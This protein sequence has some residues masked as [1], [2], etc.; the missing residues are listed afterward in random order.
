MTYATLDAPVARRNPGAIWAG[1]LATGALAIGYQIASGGSAIRVVVAVVVMGVLA[2]PSVQHPRAAVTWLFALLPFM[3][4]IR[5]LFLG[6]SGRAFLDPLLLITSAV[7]III[8][9]SMTVN[10]QMDFEGTT[11]SKLVFLL[12]VVGL[13]Q[14]FNPEQRSLLTGVTGIMINLVPLSFFFIGRTIGD[15][16]YTHRLTRMVMV[17][18]GL[19]ALYGLKQVFMGFFGFEREF[20]ANAYGALRV[21]DTTR[22]FSFFNNASEWASYAHIAF[23]VAFASMLFKPKSKRSLLLLLTAVIAY[24][25]FLIGSRGFTIKV[26]LAIVVL[27]AAR[28]RSR[29]LAMGLAGMMIG[30]AVLWSATTT[31]TGNINEK[32]AGASQLIEQQ[33]RALSDP[34]DRTKST[35]PI[36]FEQAT[37]AV[38]YVITHK[39]AGVGTGA[40]TLAGS[41]FGG[42]Q[43]STEL[44]IGDFFLSLGVPGGLLYVAIVIVAITT[45]SRVR[46]ALPGPAWVGIWAML[47]TSVGAWLLGG[48]YAIGP[49]LWFLIGAVDAAYK[50]LR[51]RGLLRATLNA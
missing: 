26:L 45:A 48:N 9:V 24:S 3:G 51:D 16:D 13:I 18:G 8:F 30:L 40:S 7:A 32:E 36:H 2:I 28:A 20:I 11:L 1:L 27:V 21:A 12:L 34:F 31:T 35:L 38:G 14:V 10:G 4:M 42:L 49:L 25:G 29:F 6:V 43:A 37:E 33:V 41:K 23:V 5:H 15:A 17:I 46:R 50:R 22:P 44:D 19:G 47:L 39:P